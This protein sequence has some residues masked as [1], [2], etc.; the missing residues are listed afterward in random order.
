MLDLA[1]VTPAMQ[2]SIASIDTVFVHE[3]TDASKEPNLGKTS[4][5]GR[6]LKSDTL[7]VMFKIRFE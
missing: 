6:K 1:A 2:P 3:V 5:R 4:S 7:K